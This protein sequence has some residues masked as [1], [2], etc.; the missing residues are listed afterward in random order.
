[1]SRSNVSLSS[2]LDVNRLC[3]Q[4]CWLQADKSPKYQAYSYNEIRTFIST[5]GIKFVSG[6]VFKRQSA[7]TINYL[8][9]KKTQATASNFKTLGFS[10]PLIDR[11]RLEF[12]I[13]KIP[14]R[15]LVTGALYEMT[16]GFCHFEC[17]NFL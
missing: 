13:R 1:M 16:C 3:L 8:T 14:P 9:P 7:M 6:S 4:N 15:V 12:R 17:P 10:R 5:I 2:R 11:L